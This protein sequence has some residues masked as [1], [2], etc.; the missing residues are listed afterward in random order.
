M[1]NETAQN[2]SFALGKQLVGTS[3]VLLLDFLLELFA[4]ALVVRARDDL[5]VNPGNDLLDHRI[6]IQ[7][8]GQKG[9]ANT[10]DKNSLL[11]GS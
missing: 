9:E 7:G 8:G 3:R 11:H 6:G 2:I 10:A 5:I 1:F 4:L